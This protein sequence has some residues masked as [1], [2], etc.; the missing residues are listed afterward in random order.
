VAFVPLR[1]NGE[2]L[3]WQRWTLLSE[4]RWPSGT[5]SPATTNVR[6]SVHTS[7]GCDARPLS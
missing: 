5:R 6:V 4:R 2:A 3:A 1:W 7:N